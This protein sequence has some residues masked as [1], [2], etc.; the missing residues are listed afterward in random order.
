MRPKPSVFILPKAS[1]ATWVFLLNYIFEILSIVFSTFLLI[2]W[3]FFKDFSTV[4][5]LHNILYFCQ[6]KNT[7]NY[8]GR[9]TFATWIFVCHLKIPP[10]PAF[11]GDRLFRPVVAPIILYNNIVAWETPVNLIMYLIFAERRRRNSF[12]PLNA[13]RPQVLTIFS[14]VSKKKC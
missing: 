8:L 10:C 6:M 1:F 11:R 13:S 3:D 12:S 5:K 4:W 14:C 7:R 9:K 2:F